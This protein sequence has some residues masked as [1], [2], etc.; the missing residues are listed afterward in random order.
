MTRSGMLRTTVFAL[1]AI[2]LA[3][4]FFTIGYLAHRWQSG[5]SALTMALASRYSP[6]V[7]RAFRGVLRENRSTVRAALAELRMARDAQE[8]LARQ[9]PFDEA[10]MREAM[11]Q[12]RTKTEALQL[13][14]Q[15]YLLTVL[16]NAES[17]A[18]D[19]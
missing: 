4:N 10:A 6:D 17:P 1:L 12:V 13:I 2:S 18:K 8:A 5:P 11:A 14:L 15:T 9:H 19:G 7:Q 16:R 3:G